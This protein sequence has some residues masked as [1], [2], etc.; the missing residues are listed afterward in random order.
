MY[1]YINF[2]PFLCGFS[3]RCLER[4]RQGVWSCGLRAGSPG[5]AVSKS[6]LQEMRWNSGV[7]LS[8]ET[9]LS[10][11]WTNPHLWK[12]FSPSQSQRKGNPSKGIGPSATTPGLPFL[13]TNYVHGKNACFSKPKTNK[14]KN[15]NPQQTISLEISVDEMSQSQRHSPGTIPALKGSLHLPFYK[16]TTKQNN[17]FSIFHRSNQ[18]KAG[19]F[20][21]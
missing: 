11:T 14:N 1:I 4:W 6:R 12:P 5:K 3:P 18:K 16:K 17:L 7:P 21:L 8:P 13:L 15:Q 9:F 10:S 2:L 20:Q 19:S